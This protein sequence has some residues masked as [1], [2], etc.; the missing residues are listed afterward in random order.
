MSILLIQGSSRVLKP[1][2]AKLFWK[3]HRR[4]LFSLT[5]HCNQ[6]ELTVSAGSFGGQ[7]QASL[8][9]A[10][11]FRYCS[12]LIQ[13]CRYPQLLVLQPC[14]PTQ[15]SDCVAVCSWTWLPSQ[16]LQA[17]V[18]SE[19]KNMA[20][21]TFFKTAWHVEASGLLDYFRQVAWMHFMV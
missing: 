7:V 3:H 13:V 21:V 19:T 5:V 4:H 16:E 9:P 6:W 15:A 2:H 14:T 11:D 10:P 18:N 20:S 1:Q 8:L 17:T 12:M